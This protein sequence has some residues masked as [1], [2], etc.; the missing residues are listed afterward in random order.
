MYICTNH[1]TVQILYHIASTYQLNGIQHYMQYRPARTISRTVDNKT[2]D[3]HTV[4]G[5]FFLNIRQDIL[6]AL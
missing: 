1:T 6:S 5:C 3:W 4:P 2:F